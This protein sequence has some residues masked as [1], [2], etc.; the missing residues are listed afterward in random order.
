MNETNPPSPRPGARKRPVDEVERMLPMGQL[1]TL[2]LQHV[3]VM[4]AGAVAVPLVIGGSLGLPKDQISYLISSD[5]FCCGIVTLLQCVGIGRFAGIRLPV[6]MSVTFAAVMPMLA[7][8]ANPD[9]G[10]TGIFGAT[11]AAGII[12]TLLVPLIGR[13][14]PLFPTVVTGVVITSIGISIMQVGIDW[15][16]GG[17]G[18]P[19]YG[20]L[21]Y[22]GTSFLVLVFILLVTRFTKGFFSNISVLLGIIFGFVVAIAMGEVSLDG[23]GEAAWFAP[24]VPFAFGWPTFDPI[25]IATLTVIMLITFIESMGMF[26]A[27]GDI[28]GHPARRGDIVRGLR[29]DG[30]GTIIGGIFNSF[31]PHLVLPE[32]RSGERDRGIESL[33]LCD[34]GG[35][36]ARL[37]PNPQ[38]V[39]AG[40]LHPVLRTGGRRHRDV[41]HGAG[42]RD[43]HPGAHRLQQQPPQPLY[44]RHQSRNW[45]DPDGLREFFQQLPAQ[46]QPLFHSGILLA[47]ISSVLLN[48]FFNGYQPDLTHQTRPLFVGPIKPQQEKA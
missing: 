2:G 23:L 44:R 29:V 38:D 19:E 34:V 13:L 31:P 43:P 17:K 16:A 42:N 25:S 37:W 28:V 30:I 32:Y 5:L 39:G 22:I 24:I 45:H 6:I 27:L 7:I 46:L 47:T 20:S 12:S 48:L 1:F 15:M 4:Y 26:L 8:G 35:D 21:R 41:R 14:M 11:I 33:G 10:L 36:P 18:N 9:L 40:R 3:L